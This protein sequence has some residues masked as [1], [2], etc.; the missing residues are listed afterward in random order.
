MYDDRRRVEDWLTEC[1]RPLAAKTRAARNL[2][3]GPEREVWDCTLEMAGRESTAILSIFKPGSL[4]SVNTSL[5][6][7]LAVRKCVL[8]VN[9][10]PALGIPTPRA[11]GHATVGREAGLVCERIDRTAWK[12]NT[13]I[14]A[15]RI[16]ARIHGL[17]EGSLSNE[18]RE[19]VKRSDPR[20]CRT[21]GGQA[22][23]PEVKT[24]VHGDYFSANILPVAGGVRIIDWETFG[25]GDP[26][27]DLGFLIGADRDLP[28]DE[29]AAVVAE[30]GRNVPV[31][32][33]HLMWHRRRWSDYWERRK[34]PPS[35]TPEA[36]NA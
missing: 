7:D 22:P 31:N 1:L 3:D 14:E 6:P 32:Q 23:P 4:D 20:E 25:W 5:P 24:L 30:Y 19:L 2:K 33:E 28:E 21:T 29:I 34:G 27:W 12:P 26:M 36:A 13:R 11:L 17:D 8:A 16:L 18:L 10:L 15:A 35:D 9:E